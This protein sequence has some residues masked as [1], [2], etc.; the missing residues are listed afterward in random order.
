MT[1]EGIAHGFGVKVV[2]HP[3]IE[4]RMRQR[5]GTNINEARLR[6]AKV[7]EGARFCPPRRRSPHV[8][9]RNVYIFPGI[10]KILHERFHIIKEDFA[11]R[12]IFSKRFM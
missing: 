4:E 11:T 12:P 3:D 9:I 8:K 1:I 7:P 5:H 10:P 2:R 6:M